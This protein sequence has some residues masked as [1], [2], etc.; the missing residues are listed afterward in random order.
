M[1]ELDRKLLAALA[2]DGRASVSSLAALMGVTRATLRARMEKLEAS[3]EIT[4]YRAVL[5]SD[6]AEAPVRGIVLLEIE[7]RGAARIAR[8]LHAMP[9]VTHVHSTHGRWDLVAEMATRTL[10]ALDAV[11]IRVRAI[12]GVSRSETSLYLSTMRR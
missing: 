12:E 4:G 1:D 6:L 11:L 2:K 5:R 10:E 3:G 8:L 9:E 7:G